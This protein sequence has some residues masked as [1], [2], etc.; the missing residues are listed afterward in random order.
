ME[1][2]KVRFMQAL[3]QDPRF[4]FLEVSL[5]GVFLLLSCCI[6]QGWAWRQIVPVVPS[7]KGPKSSGS[8]ASHAPIH[9]PLRSSTLLLRSYLRSATLLYAPLRSCPTFLSLAP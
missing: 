5:W 7:R 9:A 3:A 4:V 2:M 1:L 6:Y 8:S